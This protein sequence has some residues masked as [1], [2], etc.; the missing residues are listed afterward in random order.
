MAHTSDMC[1]FGVRQDP[2]KDVKR[3]S[4]HSIFKNGT[5][6][7]LGIGALPLST[8]LGIQVT[9]EQH[10]LVSSSTLVEGC[11]KS[12]TMDWISKG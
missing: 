11:L 5:Q 3:L 7:P 12:Q 10:S 4:K 9:V 6:R 1:L 8:Y 2:S